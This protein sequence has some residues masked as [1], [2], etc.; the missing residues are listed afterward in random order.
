MGQVTP[1]PAGEIVPMVNTT[2]ANGTY[3]GQ[4]SN[5]LSNGTLAAAF[6]R[7]AGSHGVSQ[8]NIEFKKTA[9]DPV[10]L[11]FAWEFT[12]ANGSSSYGRQYDNGTFTQSNGQTKTFTW[13]Y[14]DPGVRTPTS[15]APC[16]R[17]VLQQYVN[18]SLMHTFSTSVVC[19]L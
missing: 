9:G 7:Y 14:S 4:G 18:G 10:T 12:S 1:V 5:G 19:G 2:C 17:G 6:C 13:H 3:F 15:N 8:V 16:V 11:R